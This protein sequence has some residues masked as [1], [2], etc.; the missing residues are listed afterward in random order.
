LPPVEP[1]GRVTDSRTAILAA[2]EAVLLAEGV[3]GLTIRKVSD[4]CGFS[5]PTIYHHFRDKTGLVDA[6]LEERFAVALEVMR[7]IERGS[8]P[9]AHLIDVA[10]AYVRFSL[11]NPSHYHLLSVPRLDRDL[12]PSA[13]AARALVKRSL[14]ELAREGTLAT[15]DIDEAFEVTWAMIHGLISLHLIHPKHEFSPDLIERTFEVM[16]TGLLRTDARAR[17]GTD[18]RARRGTDARARQGTKS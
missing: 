14:E 11:D 18:A 1:G 9:A 2:T 15:S 10:R 16:T 4:R 8:D 3:E 7:G 12:V 5:A 6:L 17:R 13:E